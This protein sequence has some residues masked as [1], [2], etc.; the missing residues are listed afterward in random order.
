VS[1]P[2]IVSAPASGLV[3]VLAPGTKISLR[4]VLPAGVAAPAS[5]TASASADTF[6]PNL[7]S[8]DCVDLRPEP[9]AW[10]ESSTLEA[11]VAAGVAWLRVLV[12]GCAP[13][14]LAVRTDAGKTADLGEVRLE[15]A[16]TIKGRVV[17]TKGEGAGGA[18]VWPTLTGAAVRA[19]ADGSFEAGGLAPGATIVRAH[20]EGRFGAAAADA[21]GAPATIVLRAMGAIVGVVTDGDGVPVRDVAVA[22]RHA[23]SDSPLDR[24]RAESAT[25]DRDGRFR[26]RVASGRVRVCA[27]GEW[28]EVTVPEDGEVA[29]AVR[30]P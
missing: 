2:Q 20:A 26:M 17:D 28:V 14:V 24:G 4:L 27:G 10:K 11:E 29:V 30:R 8:E 9:R 7:E 3:F 1:A 5:L 15:P 18:S 21:G 22:V 23:F 13:A 25:T 6:S 16:V 19:A 12:P